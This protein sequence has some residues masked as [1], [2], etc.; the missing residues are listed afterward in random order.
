MLE[1]NMAHSRPTSGQERGRPQGVYLSFGALDLLDQLKAK[2][3]KSKSW[4]IEDLIREKA[5]R[6]GLKESEHDS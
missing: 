3:D 6:L 2:L 1:L 5:N 4:I